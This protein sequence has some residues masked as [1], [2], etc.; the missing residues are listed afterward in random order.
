MNF[1]NPWIDPRV[2]Q[3]RPVDAQA[4]LLRQGWKPLPPEQP[5]LLSFDGPHEDSPVV[6]VPLLDQG[7]GYPQ[8]VV[9]LITDLA[10]AEG[11]YAGDVLNDILQ[12]DAPVN[13]SAAGRLTGT[14][15]SP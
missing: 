14:P 6:G 9:E 12:R 7:R 11:R 4:Y 10:L 2:T 5:N 15:E 13:G 3:V 8:R 1:R